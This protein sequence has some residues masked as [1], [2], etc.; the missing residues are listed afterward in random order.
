WVEDTNFIKKCN[1]RAA[2]TVEACIADGLIIDLN[3]K[4]TRNGKAPNRNFWPF[5]ILICGTRSPHFI[6][7]RILFTD[8]HL[9]RQW[10][11]ECFIQN[12]IS[13]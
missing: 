3:S 8:V 7:G 5:L 9:H 6:T 1:E 13:Y 11:W 4:V 12:Y 10:S 2:I